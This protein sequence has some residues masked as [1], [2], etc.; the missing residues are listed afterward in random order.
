M[1]D[2]M[3]EALLAYVERVLA[4]KEMEVAAAAAGLEPA[5]ACKVV[6]LL[7]RA[8]AR[9]ALQSLEKSDDPTVRIEAKVLLSGA[10]TIQAEL[11]ALCEDSSAL[12]RM[13]AL[14]AIARHGVKK[15]FP[16]VSRRVRQPDFHQLGSDERKELLVSMLSLSLEHG[17]PIALELARKAGVFVSEDKEASRVAA[18]EALGTCSRSLEVAQSLRELALSRWGT[19]EE[20][21]QAASNAA[22][23]IQ[24]RAAS[25]S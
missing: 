18:I 15:M 5:R 12:V 20:T 8:N 3:E 17:E 10:E 2:T 24:H 25:V 1:P 13:A 23:Q 19:A 7:A 4:G 22:D 21:K 6:Q 14:R 9:Q 11:G 16:V